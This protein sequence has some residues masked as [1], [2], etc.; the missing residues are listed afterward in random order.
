M[1]TVS[2]LKEVCEVMEKVFG[3]DANVTIQLPSKNS[4]LRE[5]YYQFDVY[6]KDRGTIYLSNNSFQLSK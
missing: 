6:G 1:L 2:S 5:E 4:A 3:L